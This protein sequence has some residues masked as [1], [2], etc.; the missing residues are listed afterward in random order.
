MS[1]IIGKECHKC[2]FFKIKAST[3]CR[4]TRY[5][6]NNIKKVY[7]DTNLKQQAF[8]NGNPPCISLWIFIFNFLKL[9]K[10]FAGFTGFRRIKITG[11]LRKPSFGTFFF[12]LQACLTRKLSCDWNKRRVMNS[13]RLYK[14]NLVWT[15]FLI[16]SMLKII[17]FMWLTFI[18]YLVSWM[19]K[20]EIKLF[21]RER[22][23][24]P[25]IHE[26]FSPWDKK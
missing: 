7:R 5:W 24:K 10:N 1:I 2:P 8:G 20:I 12:P 26:L 19:E 17:T 16:W 14:I 15:D 25:I 4:W 11:K 21:S 18:L 3:R 9:K 22:K 23:W 6:I 13:Y